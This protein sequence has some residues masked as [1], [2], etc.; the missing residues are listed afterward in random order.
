LPLEKGFL[1]LTLILFAYSEAIFQREVMLKLKFSLK[2]KGVPKK[3]KV[4]Q[5]AKEEDK[6]FLRPLDVATIQFFLPRIPSFIETYHLT[7]MTLPLAALNILI[8]YYARQN[9]HLI[10]LLAVTYLIQH[11]CDLLDGAVGRYRNTGL[12]RWGFYMDKLVDFIFLGS[13]ALAFSLIIPEW[14]ILPFLFFMVQGTIMTQSFLFFGASLISKKSY[15]NFSATEGKLIFMIAM[16]GIGILG[17][18]WLIYL[19]MI[20]VP[21]LSAMLIPTVYLSQ[22][23]LWKSDMKLKPQKDKSEILNF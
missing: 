13:I 22:K 2:K 4:F 6:Y 3:K 21:T 17:R 18:Q 14:H 15:M 16:V 10:V 19:L 12:V 7:L 20:A 9:I 1:Y 5:G 8:G 23:Y 11:F